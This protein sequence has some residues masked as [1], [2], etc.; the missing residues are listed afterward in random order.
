MMQKRCFPMINKDEVAVRRMVAHL[1]MM[2]MID[3]PGLKYTEWS[4]QCLRYLSESDTYKDIA[5]KA[6]EDLKACGIKTDYE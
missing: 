2:A 5:L 4:I 3:R 1:T 6:I